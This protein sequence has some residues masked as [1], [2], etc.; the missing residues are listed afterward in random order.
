[1]PTKT[2]KKTKLSRHKRSPFGAAKMLAPW[3]GMGL[4]SLAGLSG[5]SST[6]RTSYRSNSKYS[7]RPNG[8]RSNSQNL[9]KRNIAG[10]LAETEFWSQELSKAPTD[11]NI[12]V[13]QQIQNDI[14][15]NQA[16]AEVAKNVKKQK[17]T[18]TVKLINNN[19]R[20]SGDLEINKL[21]Y[22]TRKTE[23]REGGN[24]YAKK[25]IKIVKELK[26]LPRNKKG[27]V[28]SN[29]YIAFNKKIAMPSTI[30]DK[31]TGIKYATRTWA[32]GGTN[33]V[34]FVPQRR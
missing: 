28:V 33:Y 1:M 25:T 5:A 12:L 15:E 27:K 14:W 19:G 22:R 11:M 13:N 24:K 30:T 7:T 10:N 8:S 23:F 3:V 4:L 20:S 16:A 2:R 6:G 21:K 29:K 18:Q 31:A 26:T 32:K 9:A 34:K 17:K